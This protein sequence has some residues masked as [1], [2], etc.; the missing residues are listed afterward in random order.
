MINLNNHHHKLLLLQFL[1]HVGS[2]VGLIVYWDPIWLLVSLL[3]KYL[4]ANIGAEIGYHRFVCHK[5][6]KTT[7]FME[8]VLLLL[9]TFS[10]LGSAIGWAANHRVHHRNSDG[11]GDP[12]PASDGWRTW[13]WIGTNT[14]ST[15]SP[16]VVK[17]LLTKKMYVLQRKYYF[18][19]IYVT[20]ALVGL[21]SMKFLVYFFLVV[22]PLSLLGGGLLNVVCHK[23]G[24]RNFETNDTSKNNFWVNLYSQFSGQGLHNNHHMY[25]SRWNNKVK[26]WEI[27]LS[28]KVIDLIRTKEDDSQMA[29]SCGR[30]PTGLCI[31]WHTLTEEVFQQKLAKFQEKNVDIK[32]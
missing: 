27:D 16:M 12:H 13:F 2:I 4:I 20:Y 15:I 11:P 10:I 26:S 24:Y 3:G 21:I 7:P 32:Q 19:F 25:P 28:S 18:T 23:W 30:S 22:G 1:V 17:D 14:K 29:C 6:F 31:G 5:S 8:G 9:G